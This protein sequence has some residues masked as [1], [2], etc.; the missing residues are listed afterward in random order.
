LLSAS[1]TWVLKPT[2]VPRFPSI[3]L[4]QVLLRNKSLPPWKKVVAKHSL[5]YPCLG[6]SLAAV[7]KCDVVQ[8]FVYITSTQLPPVPT[9]PRKLNVDNPETYCSIAIT[10]PQLP[11]T[12]CTINIQKPFPLI[13]A[14]TRPKKRNSSDSSTS[15]DVQSFPAPPHLIPTKMQSPTRTPT[16]RSPIRKQAMGITIGQKQALI[17]NLQ[18]E[19][20]ASRVLKRPQTHGDLANLCVQ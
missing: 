12:N 9:S 4:H 14:P 15:V 6:N 19:S 2:S 5:K 7:S 10:F 3:I 17:D 18:L 16:G 20:M 11:S 13:M 8:S 1:T